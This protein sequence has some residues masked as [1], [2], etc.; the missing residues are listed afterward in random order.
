MGRKLIR[1]LN[2][3]GMVEVVCRPGIIIQINPVDLTVY[4][5]LGNKQKWGKSVGYDVCKTTYRYNGKKETYHILMH[6]L[7]VYLYGDKYGKTI[8]RLGGVGCKADVVDHIDGDRSNN[9]INNL[10]VVSKR[11]NSSRESSLRSGL[12]T[13]V[14]WHKRDRKYMSYIKIDGKTKFLGY[15]KSIEAASAAYQEKLKEITL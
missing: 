6:R 9:L 4:S 11:Y 12:P 15:Y 2:G 8:N 7:V 10:Q 5:H 14:V 3:D 1:E 13:G